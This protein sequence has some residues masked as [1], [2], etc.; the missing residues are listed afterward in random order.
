VHTSVDPSTY[1]AEDIQGKDWGQQSLKRSAGRTY[2]LDL[3]RELLSPLPP[4]PQ[5]SIGQSIAQY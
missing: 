2:K 1:N 3:P 4:V 5:S